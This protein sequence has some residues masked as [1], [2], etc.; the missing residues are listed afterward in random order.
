MKLQEVKVDFISKVLGTKVMGIVSADEDEIKILLP[1][2]SGYATPVR[3]FS[4][5]SEEF[6]T[7][8]KDY[9]TKDET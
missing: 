9:I 5:T 2:P 6:C 8:C 1:T 3:E 7:M 4:I